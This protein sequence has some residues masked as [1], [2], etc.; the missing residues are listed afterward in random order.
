VRVWEVPFD[1]SIRI[2]D[3][4]LMDGESPSEAALRMLGPVGVIVHDL[5]DVEE[6]D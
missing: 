5:H 6:L 3:E 2:T 1:G 4:E